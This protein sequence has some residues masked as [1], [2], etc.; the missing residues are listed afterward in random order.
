MNSSNT[1]KGPIVLAPDIEMS[2][3][4]P[5][6]YDLLGLGISIVDGDRKEIEKH[7]FPCYF[8]KNTKFEP[9]CWDEF[10]SKH[11]KKLEELIYTGNKKKN[12]RIKEIIIEF[13]SIRK[14]WEDI[15]TELGYDYYL[16]SDNNVFDGGIINYF[17]VNYTKDMPI[18][19]T[20]SK[21]EYSSF[22]ETS[23]LLKGFLLSVDS[24]NS[25][26]KNWGFFKRIN[27]LYDI[28]E[29]E[30]QHDHNPANDAYTI[31]YEFQSILAIAKGIS[32]EKSRKMD[33]SDVTLICGFILI[34]SFLIYRLYFGEWIQTNL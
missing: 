33:P 23:S 34:L 22:Y 1:Y 21:G 10:W 24:K 16:V 12:D 6:E 9:K 20:A 14:K 17:I 18:P 5:Q 8:P 31:A 30:K 27:E 29:K 7:F 19:Y 25:L 26:K 28:P 32:K 13:Q 4:N 2:G 15:S 11:P 3:N